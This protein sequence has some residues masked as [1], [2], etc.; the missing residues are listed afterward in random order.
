MKKLRMRLN[1]IRDRVVGELGS[2][3]HSIIV[4]GQAIQPEDFSEDYSDLEILV[5][6]RSKPDRYFKYV[7]LEE[8]TERNLNI[9]FLTPDEFVSLVHDGHPLPFQAMREGVIVFDDGTYKNMLQRGFKPGERTARYME[10]F[11]CTWFSL[12]LECT[13][14][15]F[16]DDV[17]HHLY[18]CIRDASTA[19]IIREK[20]LFPGSDSQI[21]SMLEDKGLREAVKFFED[22]RDLRKGLKR[23]P[24]NPFT[25][26]HKANNVLS[27]ILKVR[28][29]D[30]NRVY[31]EVKAKGVAKIEVK[32]RDRALKVKLVLFDGEAGKL[33]EKEV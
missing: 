16:W 9:T 5:I 21:I 14:R 8:F 2:I 15:G 13:F 18:K 29:C 20:S 1:Y 11:A 31:S 23:V 32:V 4:F 7:L 6:T 17:P 19:L 30:L 24:V 28:S 12:A 27:E 26:V 10:S 33:C 22:L 3:V 25:L